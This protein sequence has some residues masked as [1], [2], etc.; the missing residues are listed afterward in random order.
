M[1]RQRI[2][3]SSEPVASYRRLCQ[4]DDIL[5]PYS[6]TVSVTTLC[7]FT[8]KTGDL[9]LR[10]VP[11]PSAQQ[12]IA[13]HLRVQSRRGSSYLSEVSLSS[14]CGELRVR[15][16]ADGFDPDSQRVEEIKTFRGAFEAISENRK[17]LH[18]AQ[19]RIY[20]WMLCE[21]RSLAHIVVALVYLDLKTDQEIVLQE[22][23]TCVELKAHFE[24]LCG[25][26]LSWA[27]QEVAHRSALDKSL[28]TLAFP[29]PSFR[30]GQR[31]LAEAI[32]RAA[33]SGRHL[34]VQAPTGIGKTLATLFPL[35][36]A[37]P[38][39][40]VDKIFFLTAKTSGR[41]VALHTLQRLTGHEERI[42]PLRVLELTARE[43]ACE[44]PGRACH[45]DACPLAKGFY[46]RLPAARE[47]AVQAAWL[48]RAGV[49]RIALAHEV[50]P[51]FLA[52]ELVHWC[53]VIVGDYNH[54]FD[55]SAV[56]FALMKQE[57]WQ[58]AV[59]V[60]EAHNL[61]QRARGMYS[62]ELT[63]EM[64][65]EVRRAAPAPLKVGL[66]KLGR[67]WRTLQQVQRERG[68][69]YQ[70]QD[71]IP[72]DFTRALQ[73]LISAMGEHFAAQP[74]DAHGL[75]QRFF[76]DAL[77]FS[78]LAESLGTHSIFESTLGGNGMLAVRNLIP[79]PFLTARFE[80]C[81]SSTCFSGTLMP[82]DFYRET[83]GLPAGST[84][85]DVGSPFSGD[86]LRVRIATDLSTR[87]RDRAGSLG[88]IVAIIA[89]QFQQRPGNYL[90][91]FSSF[92]YLTSAADAFTLRHPG[93]P[94]WRQSRAMPEPE[95]DAFI[96]RFREGGQGIGF[97]VLGGAFSEGI[98]LPGDRLVGVF[99]AT[100]GLPQH[101]EFNEVMRQRMETLFG[102]GYA[103]TYLYPGLQKVVQAAG[104]VIRTEQDT[105]VLY[106]MDDRFARKDVRRLLPGWWDIELMDADDNAKP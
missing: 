54:Y 19:S 53:D 25:A 30:P 33:L 14:Q 8:A 103:Y 42:V 16:R 15:G 20:G 43:K 73:E 38:S 29:H 27:R 9:D 66:A 86:Q 58:V 51:Y 101:D 94:V 1:G 10:F 57:E 37:E 3:G 76:F 71:T 21:T 28:S 79:A 98:D 70:A 45:G 83:L 95:R 102:E 90:A 85:L 26:Y 49:R 75:V 48:G 12:G 36:K 59:L 11:A 6:H 24:R 52:Q 99:V 23:W 35:L 92:D 5:H 82:F 60:D 96:G 56:L 93:V 32:Y 40:K 65:D 80:G 39:G 72:D 17:A 81:R 55:A 91:F 68:A 67:A 89:A 61:L 7:S 69:P 64:L 22:T 97:A 13:G 84:T 104:R 18:W 87:Q 105:G 78:R 44:Y 47:E 106:L 41:A 31:D 88:R 63:G 34:L 77:A 46:D 100:L 50:C 62:A 2:A 74:E 4:A